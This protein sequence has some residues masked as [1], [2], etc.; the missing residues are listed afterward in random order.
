MKHILKK[1]VIAALTVE[2]KTALRRH[3]PRVVAVTGN[4]GKTSTKDAV[5]AI[6]SQAYGSDRVRK[7]QKSNNSEIGLPLAI[8][9]L[10]TAWTSA[11]GWARNLWQGFLAAY[12]SRRFPDWL[13]LEVGADHPGDIE[14]VTKW[15][16]PDVAVLTR[17]S[18]T[19]VHVEFF[20]DARQVL[21]EK[22]FLARAV[23]QG[24]TIVVNGDDPQFMSVI[25]TVAARRVL[26]GRAKGAEAQ[27]ASSE[28]DYDQA[29]LPLPTGQRASIRVGGET[30]DIRLARVLGDH[31]VYPIAAACAVAHAL[32]IV[33]VAALAEAAFAS[34][35]APRG[36]MSIL[37]GANSSAL[38]DDTYN[39]SPLAA[40]EA[41]RSLARLT[42]KGK[43]IAILGDMKELGAA[44]EKAHYEIGRQAGECLHTLVTVGP[45]AKYMVRGALDAGMSAERVMSFDDSEDAGLAIRE[46]VR[47][48][49]AVLVKGS[50]SMRMERASKL[51]LADP[52]TAVDVLVRQE[53]EWGRR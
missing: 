16:H 27:I 10:E 50:Q 18:D 37:R 22:M 48:G 21:Q 5:D 36:R 43:K 30:A 23:R 52:S 26:Y 25:G 13:V 40:A 34:F 33:G 14:K 49:D 19:P 31:L 20:T 53:D 9:G 3:K 46:L 32:G 41:L 1:I 44:T 11:G 15:L 51:L 39:S 12:V 29:A 17:M 8:L 6:L 47:A 2:A 45:A 24:G 38:I 7:S 4:V 42:L 35:E 28:I